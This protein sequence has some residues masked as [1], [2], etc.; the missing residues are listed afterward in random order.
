MYALGAHEGN[1]VI[2]RRDGLPAYQ[3]T[4]VA[5][6]LYHGIGTIVRG[7]DLTASS[8]MQVYLL[9]LLGKEPFQF[10][11]H[12]LVEDASGRKLSKS[13]KSPALQEY[14]KSGGTRESLLAGFCKWASIPPQ[15]SIAAIAE[16][17]RQDSKKA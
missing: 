7:A 14:R 8:A 13:A 9:Q 4:S 2:R 3:V 12:P 15:S 16:A 1:F 11:H 17:M 5:D 6:D 10:F